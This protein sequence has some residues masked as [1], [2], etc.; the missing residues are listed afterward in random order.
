METFFFVFQIILIFSVLFIERKRPGEAVLWVVIF[1]LFPVVGC[2]FYLIFGST[3]HI[4]LSRAIRGRRFHEPYEKAIETQIEQLEKLPHSLGFNEGERQ[5][6]AFNLNSSGAG[7]GLF[8]H[9]DIFTTGRDHYRTLFADIESAQNHIHVA[10]YAIHN[11][12]VGKELADLLEKKA[13]EGVKVRVL[14]DGLSGLAA[15][16]FLYPKIKRA[17]GE[18]RLMKTLFTHYRY[19]RKIVVVDGR[20]GYTGGMNIGAKY[21]GEN[22]KKSPWRDTQIRIEG[23]SVS[24]LQAYFLYDWLFANWTGDE[25]LQLDVD[26]L[27]PEHEI[28]EETP[29]QIIASGIE[30]EGKTVK[31]NYARMITLAKQKVVFQ[32]PYFIPSDTLFDTIRIALASGVEVIIQLPERSSSFFLDPVTRYFLAQLIPL[33]VKV[34][35]YDGYV[36]SKTIRIDEA[37]TCIGSVNIDVRSLDIDDE[38]CAVMYNE[39]FAKKYDVILAEDM[40]NSHE[41]DYEAFLNRGLWQ[42]FCERFFFLFSAFM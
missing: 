15:W 12:H 17:G 25:H 9:V 31:L 36:H 28:S 10:F 34:M 29:C 6:I 39:G 5:M 3:L 23:D 42:R 20:V 4:K 14:C 37:V 22:P 1:A 8:N 24:Q 7:I 2:A 40:N 18:S 11:D 13:R 32:T 27:F 21:L 19:H 30:M 16:A 38:I 26:T 41:I 33:G 35:L